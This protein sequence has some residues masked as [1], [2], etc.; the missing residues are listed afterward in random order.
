M[1]LYGIARCEKRGS[2]AVGGI[3]AEN[4]RDADH[5]IDLPS[6]EIDWQKTKDNIHLVR[7]DDWTQAIKDKIADH[8]ITRVRKDAIPMIDTIYTA[9]AGFFQQRDPE[10]T[11]D[12]FRDC[13]EFHKARFGQDN[14]INAVIHLDE[15]GAPHMHVCHVPIVDRGDHYALSAKEQ[16]GNRATYYEF[17]NAFYEQVSSRWELDRGETR[18][19]AERKIH[20]DTLDYKIETRQAKLDQLEADIADKVDRANEILDVSESISRDIRENKE[21]LEHLRRESNI[22][23]HKIDASMDRLS[24]IGRLEALIDR[25]RDF[26]VDRIEALRG[27]I[28]DVISRLEARLPVKLSELQAENYDV[29]RDDHVGTVYDTWTGET[30]TYQGYSMEVT[31]QDDTVTVTGAVLFGKEGEV[32]SRITDPDALDDIISYEH[33]DWEPALV[34]LADMLGSIEEAKALANDIMDDIEGQAETDLE[35]SLD[36]GDGWGVTDDDL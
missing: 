35:D 30:L 13:L 3:E 32:E 23:E 14:V 1:A 24:S 5:P 10:E 18:D 19:P 15:S 9:S 33:R 21:T 16:M 27:K 29:D 22:I 20:K 2:T 17:Q 7:S 6:S 34:Q 8:G 26:V 31:E 36:E 4:N 25:F 12:Y 11:V 28:D